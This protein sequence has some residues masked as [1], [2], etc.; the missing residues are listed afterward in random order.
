MTTHGMLLIGLLTFCG[1]GHLLSAGEAEDRAAARKL[2]EDGNVQEAVV[3]F[4]KLL[5]DPAADPAQV[6]DDLGYGL[7]CLQRLGRQAEMDGLLELSIAAHGGNWRLL[8]QA[9]LAYGDLLQHSGEVI[10]GEFRRGH[11]HGQEGR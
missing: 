2:R 3:L 4:R 10:G 1:V 11:G 9:A 8:Q 5:A 7:Y 6:P